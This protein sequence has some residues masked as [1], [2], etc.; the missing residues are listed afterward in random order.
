[1]FQLDA[2]HRDFYLARYDSRKRIK[3]KVTQSLIDLKFI[4]SCQGWWDGIQSGT[5]WTNMSTPKLLSFSP[6]WFECFIA[7][8]YHGSQAVSVITETLQWNVVFPSFFSVYL[9]FPYTTEHFQDFWGHI[10]FGCHWN[11][12][13]L[14]KQQ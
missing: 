2:K 7:F 12:F 13:H 8:N 9:W 3:T 10:S 5:V 4:W 14:P 11:F 1:M 6:K